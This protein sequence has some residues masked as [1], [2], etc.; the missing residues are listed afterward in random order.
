[1]YHSKL[2]DLYTFQ[3]F[4]HNSLTSAKFFGLNIVKNL[5]W[6]TYIEKL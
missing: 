1:M 6:K 4:I 3:S 5:K 2:Q